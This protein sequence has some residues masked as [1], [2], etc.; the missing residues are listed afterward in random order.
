VAPP[1]CYSARRLDGAT[2]RAAPVRCQWLP[3]SL[4]ARPPADSVCPARPPAWSRGVAWYR[5]TW[6]PAA[7]RLAGRGLPRPRACGRWLPAWLPGILLATLMFEC[8][9]P[10]AAGR[11]PSHPAHFGAH[12][13]PKVTS[14]GIRGIQ[15]SA[16][17]LA[18]I[19]IRR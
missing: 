9:R 11:M 1:E 19:R 17:D 13:R 8:S 7:A 6:V 18:G 16:E 5:L 15:V 3:R 12:Q 4:P 14:M 2:W 10:E